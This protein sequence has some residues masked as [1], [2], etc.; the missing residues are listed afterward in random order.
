M[1]NY[2][3][4]I[5]SDNSSIIFCEDGLYI[6]E[7]TSVKRLIDAMTE[8]NSGKE[9]VDY[10]YKKPFEEDYWISDIHIVSKNT[11]GSDITFGGEKCMIISIK[12]MEITIPE[13]IDVTLIHPMNKDILTS[14]MFYSLEETPL[15]ILMDKD[16]TL[17]IEDFTIVYDGGSEKMYNTIKA[18]LSDKGL[19]EDYSGYNFTMYDD[20]EIYD[21]PY[22][23]IDIDNVSIGIY[24]KDFDYLYNLLI[25]DK[26]KVLKVTGGNNE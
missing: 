17:V 15:Y 7:E 22:V 23:L 3:I 9:E 25:Y 5:E 21:E 11:D 20:I 26:T 10:S 12:F 16:S 8:I 24:V 13:K 19:P 14:V 18:I 2:K 1:K 4:T 6:M